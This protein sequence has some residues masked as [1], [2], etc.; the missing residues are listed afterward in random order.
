MNEQ[1]QWTKSARDINY[2]CSLNEILDFLACALSFF[3]KL[4]F[5]MIICTER[6]ALTEMA[7][8]CKHPLFSSMIIVNSYSMM[9]H[10]SISYIAFLVN[11]IQLFGPS[12]CTRYFIQLFSIWLSL[13]SFLSLPLS[14]FLF[15][16]FFLSFS[17]FFSF[18]IYFFL[19]HSFSFSL[20]F[21]PSLDY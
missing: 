7:F 5:E 15:L 21:F 14:L 1:R 4:F 10:I 6:Y 20:S 18:S 2:H 16:S 17:L 9:I 3:I 11:L 13:S 8:L 12:C 19:S